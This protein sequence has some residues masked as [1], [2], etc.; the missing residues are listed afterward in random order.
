[1]NIYKFILMLKIWAITA[2]Y[3]SSQA[4]EFDTYKL[5]TDDQISVTVFNE[6]ELSIN[7]I[8]IGENG[9]ISMPLIG[10]IYVKG[11]TST[12]VEKTLTAR[13][14]EGYLKKPSITVTINEYRPFYINGEIK[15][16]G[17]YPYRKGL[18]V[19]MAA[20]LAGGFSERASKT[21][22]SLISEENK[23]LR[24]SVSLNDVVKPGDVITINESFF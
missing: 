1:M 8:R 14:L 20:T 16:P 7:K 10:Q 3:T 21:N 4:N 13:L 17:S 5:S 2:C 18:T 9:A 19:D 12:E 15:K 23:N 6:P 24:K 22:I 11:L